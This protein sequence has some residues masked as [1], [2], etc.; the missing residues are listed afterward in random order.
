MREAVTVRDGEIEWDVVLGAAPAGRGDLVV[1][2]VLS[3]VSRAVP[4]GDTLRVALPGGGELRMAKLV[5][6][7]ATGAVLYRALP[8]V[9]GGRLR[10]EVPDEAL[11]RAAYPVTLDP[12]VSPERTVSAATNDQKSSDIAFDGT[13]YLVVWTDYRNGTT[14]DIYGARVRADGAVL[15]SNGILISTFTSTS[16]Q[17]NP[18]LTYFGPYYLVVWEDQRSGAGSDIYGARVRTNGTPLDTIA[19]PFSTAPDV[20]AKPQIVFSGTDHFL[21]VWEDYRNFDSSGPDIYGTRF[22]LASG[23]VDPLGI[24][25]SPASGDQTE[26]ALAYYGPHYLVVWTDLPAPRGALPPRISGVGVT[27]NGT[28]FDLPFPLPTVF[29]VEPDVAFDGTSLLVV[30]TTRSAAGDSDIYGTRLDGRT[31][32]RLDGGFSISV[33]GHG[34]GAPAVAANGAF[35]VVWVDRRTGIDT[36]IYGTRV[37]S[38]GSVSDPPGFAISTATGNELSP[39]LI[40]GKGSDFVTTYDRDSNNVYFRSVNPK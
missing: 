38:N 30:W 25:I 5:V 8:A 24:L 11:A 39:A 17:I 22:T 26:P 1:S 40:K 28:T 29:G 19:A 2:A 37:T 33:A 7:D 20:Q 9:Q 4:D 6:K 14:S 23:V 12:T 32:G 15:D 10:L 34:Q 13:N 31:L 35:L 3:G 21:V 16:S 27:T 36:D 18:T